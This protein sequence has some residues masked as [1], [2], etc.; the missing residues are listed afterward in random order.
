MAYPKVIQP[1]KAGQIGSEI[2]RLTL[3]ALVV[4]L[5][6]HGN[7]PKKK[8]EKSAPASGKLLSLTTISS[9]SFR[10]KWYWK[11]P[12]SAQTVL[13]STQPVKVLAYTVQH[14]RGDNAP[15]EASVR[16]CWI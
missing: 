10:P 8:V 3:P 12:A 11:R 14:F 1:W 6:N 9:A 13:T 2:A 15:K 7:A 4:C 16:N 5:N